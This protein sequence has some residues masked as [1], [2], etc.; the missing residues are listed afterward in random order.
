MPLFCH[1]RPQGVIFCGSRYDRNSRHTPLDSGS[2]FSE[3]QS[4]RR[5]PVFRGGALQVF[6]VLPMIEVGKAVVRGRHRRH[7]DPHAIWVITRFPGNP[8]T[9]RGGG[10]NEMAIAVE[11]AET[12]F[13]GLSIAI[14]TLESRAKAAVTR[15]PRRP[16]PLHQSRLSCTL[17]PWQTSFQ[18]P[19]CLRGPCRG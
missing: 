2:G 14:L 19:F 4:K 10:V 16:L 3:F 8:I 18:S 15:A 1:V 17:G 5:H 11:S 13:I 9:G 7:G 6:W 12:A